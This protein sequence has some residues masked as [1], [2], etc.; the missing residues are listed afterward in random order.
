MLPQPRTLFDQMKVI[1]ME[2]CV[3]ALY[4][5]AELEHMDA[6]RTR[7][8]SGMPKSSENTKL[9]RFAPTPSPRPMS[10]HA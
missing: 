9:S 5:R 6:T 4:D 1:H 7:T 3:R 10:A 2:Q 8:K